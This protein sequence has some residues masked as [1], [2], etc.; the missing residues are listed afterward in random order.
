M[1]YRIES[2]KTETVWDV[3]VYRESEKAYIDPWRILFRSNSLGE[4][5][6]Y[7]KEQRNEKGFTFSLAERKKIYG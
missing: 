1:Q 4:A 6:K 5:Y 3:K 2:D 7:L